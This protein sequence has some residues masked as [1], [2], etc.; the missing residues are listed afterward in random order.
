MKVVMAKKY[1]FCM[2]VQRAVEIATQIAEETRLRRGFSRLR[3]GQVGGQGATVLHQIVHNPSVSKKLQDKGVGEVEGIENVRTKTVIF[4]AHG[5]SP[6]IR[7]KAK[8]LKLKAIDATCPLV[9]KVHGIVKS[10]AM[11]GYEFIYV[12]HKGH[13]EPVGVMGVAPGRVYLIER[14]EEIEELK[15][16][17][18][19]KIVVVTQ[20]TLS[21]RDTEEIIDKIKKKFP[22]ALIFNTICFETSDRQGALLEILDDVDMVVVVGGKNSSNSLRLADLARRSGKK[23]YLVESDR[24]LK[25]EWFKGIKAVGLTA[26]ASTPEEETGKVKKWIKS[27]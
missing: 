20:T 7:L 9:L 10:Y 15:I 18:E 5:V 11:R 14:I 4:S 21:V 3:S 22:K 1:G 24:D 19:E 27:I 12:G 16:K 6:Q 26:G 13:P 2:G 23:S 17:N 25:K 8:D